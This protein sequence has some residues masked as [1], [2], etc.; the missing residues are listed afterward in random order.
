MDEMLSRDVS[1][2]S[3]NKDF[4]EAIWDKKLKIA[5]RLALETLGDINRVNK[6]M[7]VFLCRGKNK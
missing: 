3:E 4:R 1:L 6:A 2:L 7:D 5:Q